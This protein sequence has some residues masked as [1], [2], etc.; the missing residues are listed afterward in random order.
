[1]MPPLNRLTCVFV[2][3][4]TS[5]CSLIFLPE[6]AIILLNSRAPEVIFRLG[7][8]IWNVRM[9][10]CPSVV[11]IILDAEGSVIRVIYEYDERCINVA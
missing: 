11:L 2:C 7:E 6:L 3:S 10:G 9:S 1:M 5:S 8:D 4:F